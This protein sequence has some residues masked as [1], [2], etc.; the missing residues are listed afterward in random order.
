MRIAV[1][2]GAT[3]AC[4][5]LI[6][7]PSA[8][9]CPEGTV[10]SAYKGNGICAYI[11]QGATKAVQCTKMVNSCPHGTTHEHKKSDPNDYCCP[12][13]IAHEQSKTCVWRGDAP[14]C[15]EN[16][17]GSV[18]QFKGSARDKDGAY[19]NAATKKWSNLFGKDCLSG[20]KALCCHY[21]G[22]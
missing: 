6:A 20:S 12:E 18:E 22:R 17:C 4:L 15:G 14:F 1:L 3:I 11:G 5:L 21:T 2:T 9:A 8:Y 13:K 16:S 19:F 10:F 7:T